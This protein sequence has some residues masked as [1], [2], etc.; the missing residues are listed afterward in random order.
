MPACLTQRCTVPC[1]PLPSF[2]PAALLFDGDR[3]ACLSAMLLR[4]LISQLPCAAA[5]GVRVGI[6][7]TAYANGA[8]SDYIRNNLGCDVEVRRGPAG[9]CEGCVLALL[10]DCRCQLPTPV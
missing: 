10:P 4:D 6:I 5:E 8:A 3:I 1:A 9:A 2:P 7:Q